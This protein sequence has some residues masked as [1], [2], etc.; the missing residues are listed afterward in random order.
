MT[1]QEEFLY[2]VQTA[3]L[4][5][6]IAHKNEEKEKTSWINTRGIAACAI[7]RTK[8]LEKYD[9]NW[10]PCAEADKF[11]NDNFANDL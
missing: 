1:K 2:I 9:K 11:L 3:I 5:Y 10:E 4:S 6:V 7:E 8:E